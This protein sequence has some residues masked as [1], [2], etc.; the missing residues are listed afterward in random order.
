LN[1]R[2]HRASEDY[3][4]IDPVKPTGSPQIQDYISEVAF[5]LA[6]IAV[7]RDLDLD[8]ILNDPQI[9]G[10]VATRVASELRGLARVS[11]RPELLGPAEQ[12][13]IR[14]LAGNLVLFGRAQSQVQFRPRIRGYGVLRE[15][16]GDISTPE[17]LIEVKSVTR[18]LRSRDIRQVFVYLALDAANV[19]R[20]SRVEFFNPKNATVGTYDI[21]QM[22][23]ELSGGKPHLLVLAEFLSHFE[24]REFQDPIG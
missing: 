6:D 17:S 5:S 4:G 18:G 7:T 23:H 2:V 15:C 11:L 13:E 1:H 3:Y 16:A 21:R 19:E 14:G 10:E 12:A 8:S 20:W 22:I 24:K 9:F